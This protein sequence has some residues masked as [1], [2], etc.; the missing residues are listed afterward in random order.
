[1]CNDTGSGLAPMGI[2]SSRSAEG[3]RAETARRKW[4][5]HENQK[6][7]LVFAPARCYSRQ[8][9]PLKNAPARTSAGYH[10]VLLFHLDCIAKA[11]AEE[12][13]HTPCFSWEV[14]LHKINHLRQSTSE[15]A[16]C[17]QCLPT[18]CTTQVPPSRANAAS[19]LCRRAGGLN[20][21]SE[22]A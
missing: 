9:L 6:P 8:L 4:T 1:M 20:K 15:K 11:A 13:R 5:T 2:A 16:R 18:A 3:V 17:T 10:R 12:K 7:N 19:T 21:F 14:P 22:T